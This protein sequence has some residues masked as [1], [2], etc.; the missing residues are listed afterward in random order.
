MHLRNS[1]FVIDDGF[2]NSKAG[3]KKCNELYILQKISGSTIELCQSRLKPKDFYNLTLLNDFSNLSKMVIVD[4]D[5]FS[6]WGPYPISLL[7]NNTKVNH[8]EISDASKARIYSNIH[9]T[10]YSRSKRNPLNCG[11]KKKKGLK[12][13]FA[14]RTYLDLLNCLL[15]RCKLSSLTHTGTFQWFI[16][17]DAWINQLQIF[18]TKT[19]GLRLRHLSELIL[20]DQGKQSLPNFTKLLAP[21]TSP[22]QNR[23]SLT[24]LHTLVLSRLQVIPSNFTALI[25][26]LQAS[27]NLKVLT[28][29]IESMET[30]LKVDGSLP[31]TPTVEEF[32][33]EICDFKVEKNLTFCLGIFLDPIDVV[34]PSLRKFSLESRRRGLV[35]GGEVKP[36]NIKLG[37]F[38][39]KLAKLQYL[40][41]LNFDCDICKSIT[42][43]N[44]DKCKNLKSLQVI[45]RV[46]TESV[47]LKGIPQNITNLDLRY[48]LLS[49]L[50][51]PGHQ[52]L[53]AGCLNS[54]CQSKNKNEN[55][56][57]LTLFRYEIYPKTASL[58]QF[59]SLTKLELI[60]CYFKES[61]LL[62]IL[63][64]Q[65][66]VSLKELSLS[67]SYIVDAF[68][69]HVEAS[70]LE[71]LEKAEIIG[72]LE[73]LNLSEFKLGG[74]LKAPRTSETFK[75]LRNLDISG[76][77]LTA[78]EFKSIIS[79]FPKLEKIYLG[80]LEDQSENLIKSLSEV[81][82]K[83]DTTRT[84]YFTTD[85]IGIGD[86]EAGIGNSEAF[87]LQERIEQ[88]ARQCDAKH[89]GAYKVRYRMSLNT[90]NDQSVNGHLYI[91]FGNSFHQ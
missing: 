36:I 12:L 75:E 22:E 62:Q 24:R 44:L 39:K 19:V 38:L 50:F 76:L 31:I 54:L 30:N 7:L 91:L 14:Y 85:Y 18:N 2:S 53:L 63:S 71:V 89:H 73:L 45:T 9:Y 5:N 86:S 48:P 42:L 10:Q 67:K 21:Y 58:M 15:K 13:T 80:K 59:S 6:N 34:F 16:I 74:E 57:T 29:G 51:S 20:R 87:C 55:L 43:E 60:E 69:V 68:G 40:H 17:N 88:A 41:T 26:L 52:Q 46:T 1:G 49:L 77:R 78:E 23:L 82:T 83:I 72:Q 84:I 37:S 8:V 35:Y 66:L 25:N 61:E 79:T 70:I 27:K 47:K 11:F 32:T 81:T 28:I 64:S 4:S 56:E 33:L 65:N 3:V 90:E